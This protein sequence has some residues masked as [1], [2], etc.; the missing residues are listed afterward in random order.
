MTTTI[1]NVAAGAAWLAATSQQGQLEALASVWPANVEVRYYTSGGALLRTVTH[2]PWVID[3]AATPRTLQLGPYVSAVGSGTGAAAY[4]MCSLPGGA[5]VLRADVSLAASVAA[6]P[7]VN[8]A[9]ALEVVADSG[10]PSADPQ[11]A[12][13]DIWGQSNAVSRA[14][15]ADISQAPLSADPELAAFD[16]GT[17]ARV[18]I[19]NGSSFVNLQPSSFNGSTV[20]NGDFGPEFG[21]AVRW[22]RETTAGVLYI[23]KNAEGGLSI[24][25]FAPPSSTWYSIGA[26][27]SAQSSTWL[28]NN[29]VTIHKRGLMWTQGETNSGQTQAWYQSRLSALLAAMRSDNIIGS[30]SLAVIS[31]M[32]LTS[33]AFGQG[34]FDAKAAY[35]S[36]N[37]SNSVTLQMPGYLSDGV[38]LTGRGTVQHAYDAYRAI[39][40]GAQINV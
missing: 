36:S 34:V 29:G 3:T 15:R 21:L 4:A 24:E 40:G 20:L 38:H 1:L 28:A 9:G 39:F 25:E 26:A 22:M 2:G 6:G 17:F 32:P 16:A 31:Q 35:V 33:T 19:W 23:R 18:K 37:S 14:K 10:L 8:L 30:D 5:D 7:R 27:Q 11:N 13:M 12:L